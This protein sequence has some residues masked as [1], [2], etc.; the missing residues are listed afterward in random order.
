MGISE[1]ILIILSVILL[2]VFLAIMLV[3]NNHKK[4]D[5]KKATKESK[6]VE[7]QPESVM[8][9]QDGI[10]RTININKIIGKNKEEVDKYFNK[11][12]NA[13]TNKEIERI[14]A[15]S[16]LIGIVNL[17]EVGELDNFVSFENED[18]VFVDD[19]TSYSHKIQIGEINSD[20]D[21]KNGKNEDISQLKN[22]FKNMSAEIKTLV[23]SSLD[24]KEF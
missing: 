9:S 20:L 17:E 10:A 4:T 7:A 15:D 16:S 21:T 19:R 5:S 6:K 14:N 18:M 13:K 1:I 22:E 2:G 12:L 11:V 3:A 8:Q 23:V 24:R